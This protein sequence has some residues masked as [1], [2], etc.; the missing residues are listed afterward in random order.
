MSEVRQENFEIPLAPT[1]GDDIQN[2]QYLRVPASSWGLDIPE[3]CDWIA[4]DPD[5]D[6]CPVISSYV[7]R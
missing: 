6:D 3:L 5:E 4:L 2:S 7:A 1:A